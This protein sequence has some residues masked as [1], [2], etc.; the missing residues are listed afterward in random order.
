MTHTTTLRAQTV[1]ALRS[2]RDTRAS[3]M[4]TISKL[5]RLILGSIEPSEARRAKDS[6]SIARFMAGDSAALDE[7]LSRAAEPM[8][9]A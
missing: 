6:A 3:R 9:G 2:M 5:A 4:A 7:V 8:V 1:E